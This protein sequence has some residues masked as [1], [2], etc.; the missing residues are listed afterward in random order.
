MKK[1]AV[2]SLFLIYSPNT[3]I[4]FTL[5]LIVDWYQ[6]SNDMMIQIQE[7]ISSSGLDWMNTEK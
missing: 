1:Q 2:S 7:M 6:I 4:C 3:N 5:V